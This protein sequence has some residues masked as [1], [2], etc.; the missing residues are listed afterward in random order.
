MSYLHEL[1]YIAQST[2]LSRSIELDTISGNLS[3]VNTIGYKSV[4][5]N[6]QE[7]LDEMKFGG[8][9]L[10]STQRVMTQGSL[11]PSENA[12]DVAISGEGFYA[13]EKEDGEIAYT[14]DG[15]FQ[16]DSDLN[17]VDAYGNKLVWEGEIPEDASSI[18]VN[19]DGRVLAFLND[20]AGWTEAGQINLYKVENPSGMI[21]Q[22]SSLWLPTDVS[23]EVTEGTPGTIGYGTLV[24]NTVEQANVD[25]SEELS[26]LVLLEKH[27]AL[28]VRSFEYADGM[29][30]Q[31]ISM[32][33]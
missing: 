23:G 13:V 31:A 9:Y 14:R 27:Y 26:N 2:M 28:S 4:R 17:I 21:S 29:L 25:I 22:G 5:S 30:R 11:T 20:E 1:M 3:N 12:L 19:Q 33:K 6:F 32:R 8:T 16:L 24:G 10:Q 7:I 15:Q 18:R